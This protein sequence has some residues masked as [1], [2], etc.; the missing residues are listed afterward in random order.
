[1]KPNELM[2]GDYVYNHRNWECPVVE[3]HKDSAVVI[4]KHYGEEEFLLS[5]LRPIPLTPEILEK[6]FGFVCEGTHCWA[7]KDDFTGDTVLVLWK[8]ANGFALDTAEGMTIG[9]QSVNEL[10]HLFRLC[11]MAD[12][13]L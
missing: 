7:L 10:Q 12:I 2:I 8:V 5:D 3:I 6:K 13:Q 11:G 9:I 1:M 4:A